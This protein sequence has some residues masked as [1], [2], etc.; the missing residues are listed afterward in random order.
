MQVAGAEREAAA[1]IRALEER[2]PVEA[3][4]DRMSSTL[5]IIRSPVLTGYGCSVLTFSACACSIKSIRLGSCACAPTVRPESEQN[6]NTGEEREH[7]TNA[8]RC[9]EVRKKHCSV[10][11]WI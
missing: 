5:F 2:M 3:A 7:S 11:N 8:H 1:G 4:V 10:L 9:V 6:G